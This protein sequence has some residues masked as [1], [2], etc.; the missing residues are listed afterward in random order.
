MKSKELKPALKT[1]HP[2]LDSA[3]G[4]V[5]EVA[6]DTRVEATDSCPVR[7]LLLVRPSPPL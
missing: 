6:K 7:Q 2:Q 5:M 4:T 3:A 1:V